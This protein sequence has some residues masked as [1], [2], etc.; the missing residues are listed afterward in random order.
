MTVVSPERATQGYLLGKDEGEAFWLL[1]MLEVIKIGSEET[2]GEFGLLDITARAGDGSPWHVHPDE[3]EWFYVLE[4]DFTVYV[5]DTRLSLQTGSFAFGP[6]GVPH[7]FIAGPDGGRALIGFAPFHFEGFLR[8][9][10]EPATER[11]LPAPLEAPRTWSGCSR[12]AFGTGCTSSG[13][14]ARLRA[15]DRP[16][17]CPRPPAG[18]GGR[19]T[20]GGTVNDV[21]ITPTDDGPY[22]VQGNITLLDTEGTATRSATRLRSAAAVSRAR[23][24]S[25]TARTSRRASRR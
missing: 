4:G 19:A 6:K 20:T 1:G 3:D 2:N 14:P 10:G 18:T 25:A 12:S 15:T 17:I 16:P 23:S 13:P 8:E 21:T 5:G 24:P 9:V 11:V 7:T 22:L